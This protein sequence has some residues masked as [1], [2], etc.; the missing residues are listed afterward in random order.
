LLS[1]PS[2]LAPQD[3]TLPRPRPRLT[4]ADGDFLS[5]AGQAPNGCY[6][7][8][9][10]SL[11]DGLRHWEFHGPGRVIQ[12]AAQVDHIPLARRFY[13]VSWR[14]RLS[15]RRLRSVRRFFN[16]VPLRRVYLLPPHSQC[17]SYPAPFLVQKRESRPMLSRAGF[18]CARGRA[19]SGR[20]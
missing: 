13:F 20:R 11:C 1:L 4:A 6:I 17:A 7:E 12:N 16:S 2:A 18:F 10:S 15:C 5:W 19:T 14:G 8:L 3:E 9:W